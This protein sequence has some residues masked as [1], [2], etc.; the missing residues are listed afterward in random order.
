MRFSGRHGEPADLGHSDIVRHLLLAPF[1]AH[2]MLPESARDGG[3][4][5]PSEFSY[6]ENKENVRFRDE[7]RKDCRKLWAG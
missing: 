5:V 6:M 1:G 2:E 7:Q 4:W 3:D